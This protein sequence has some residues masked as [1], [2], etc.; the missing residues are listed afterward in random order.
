MNHILLRRLAAL[1]TVVSVLC[2]ASFSR[3]GYP[4]WKFDPA[5][6]DARLL[7]DWLLQDGSADASAFDVQ[8]DADA[9]FALVDRVLKGL[10]N[11]HDADSF[12]EENAYDEATTVGAAQYEHG[13]VDASAAGV[14]ALRERTSQLVAEKAPGS[15]PRWRELYRAACRV[16]RARRLADAAET[17]PQFVYTKHFVIGASHYAYTEDVTDE[18]YVDYSS[19]RQAGGQL[20]RAT[21]APDGSIRNE[22]LVDSP[23]GMIRDPD[24]SWDGKRVL[25]SMRKDLV[26]DDF[27]IYEY[28]CETKEVRQITSG[29]GVAD[30]EPIYLPNGDILFGS[31][32]C[33]QIT[34]CWWTEVSN[35][36][37]CD[38][39]G[40][41]LRRVSFDQVTV[42]Y[43][44]LLDDGRVIY[45]RW[46]YNDR[47]QIYP[48]PLFQMNPDGTAQT[49]FYGNNSYFP[50]TIMHARGVPGSDLVMAIAGGHHTYQNGKL[51]MIDRSKGTQENEGCTL[52]AP[53]RETPADKIDQYGQQG[54]LFQY[55]WPLDESTLFCAYL[56]EG[57]A[58]KYPVPFGLY[59]FDVDGARELLA[60]D[61]AISC[62][63]PIALQEREIPTTRP[64]QVDL[65]QTTGKYYVQDVYEGPG[66][67][68]I[69]RGVVTALRVV[70]LEFR[71][72]GVGKN[73][74]SGP[75]GG[76]M[77]CTPPAVRNG[78]W[79][80][81]HVLGEVAVE[82]DG[83]A[84]FE[85]PAKTPVYFQLLDKNGDVVQ[86]MRSWSTLQ[87]GETFGCVGC[88]EPK[89]SVI[90]NAATNAGSTT[91]ALRKGAAKLQPV[92]FP[93][94]GARHDA[95]FS[96]VRDV[97]PILDHHCVSCHTGGQDKP[98]SL[99]GNVD[100]SAKGI[101]ANELSERAFSEAY[102]N[103]TSYG[104][105]DGPYIDWLGIQEGPSMLP[106]YDS[107]ACKSKLISM[108]RGPDGQYGG[109]DENH[110]EVKL[111]E[112]DVKTLALWID[113][114][115][116]FC[117]DYV[118]ANQWTVADRAQYEYYWAK[119]VAE[120][121]IDAFNVELKRVSIE[122]GD[123]SVGKDSANIEFGG[124]ADRQAFMEGYVARR[125]PSIARRS[126]D[127]NVYRNLALNPRDNQGDE[128][129][130]RVSYPHASSNS[131]YAYD[132]AFAAK[133]AIDGRKENKGHGSAFPSW[134]P[135]LRT[136][137]WLNVDFGCDV[138]IDKCV[139]YV[140]A[141]FPHDDVWQSGTLE[142]SDGST[143]EITF[144][145]TA[146]P[147]EFKFDKRRVRSVRLTNLKSDAP[148]KWRG[149]TEIEFWGVSVE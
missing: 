11:A 111:G 104:D 82:E 46:D 27:H 107:G 103:L 65:S 132:E 145:P 85:V 123:P 48:Q 99:L 141:D 88:H 3:A 144:R 19:N 18:W 135:N 74:N 115:V 22:V 12:G 130:V 105:H 121:E 131:E 42:N 62:G 23:K 100:V 124:L 113:L 106:P 37:T 129:E 80:V 119:R 45:T 1:T 117:G 138:E 118:E 26:D 30:I 116:P 68:G 93:P 53:V 101:E 15:D 4:D 16:R 21:F 52:V 35:F 143:E 71:A 29:P 73:G 86:T 63:Q 128:M 31:T 97:Q 38:A 8:T 127:L 91:I 41:F 114:L 9:A 87:P 64:S 60:Y 84:Y 78:S 133:N 76:A 54:E 125:L 75:A 110:K 25:F 66:L 58:W 24:V 5:A 43:P 137:L 77:S 139:I 95:G 140:R 109:Q 67:K 33:T 96:F 20:I 17:A 136:D 120:D 122:T 102:L 90:E 108:F 50:T 134:G 57:G 69:E 55:P 89:G 126:G 149:I 148:L 40:Q 10:E 39:N 70:A 7:Q 61:P 72:A 36:Y 47:G 32:R 146:E 59:W 51:I 147:Q 44:K 2:C 28:D 83:S 79:D 49:E 56:P 14:A 6:F 81:K 112:K 94:P 92:M 13:V 98:F 142:F 34:D